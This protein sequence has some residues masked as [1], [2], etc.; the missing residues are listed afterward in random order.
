MI[1]KRPQ[2]A[3]KACDLA[4]LYNSECLWHEAHQ[5]HPERPE[6]LKAI[7]KSFT[8]NQSPD[9]YFPTTK[10]ASFKELTLVHDEDYLFSLESSCLAGKSTFQAQGNYLCEDSFY[11]IKAAAG[12]AIEAAKLALK[13]KNAF[14]LTRPPG[15]H[16]AR[17]TAEGFC[18][19]NHAALACETIKAEQPDAKVLILDIDVHHGNGTQKIYEYRPDVFFYSIHISPEVSYPFTGASEENGLEK[20]LDYTLNSPLPDKSTGAEWLDRINH[21]LPSVFTA[22]SPDFII[23]SLGFDAHK[24]DPT[25]L[26]QLEDQDFLAAAE[27]IASLAKKYQIPSTLLLEGGYDSATLERLTADFAQYFV[28]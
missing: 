4:V 13:G 19:I 17:R 3:T 1:S 21:K 14:A 7:V 20:G 5:I 9:F 8:N 12:L 11:S 18:F 2:T 24:D 6:R 26:M 16:A 22:F 25:E 15:H 28:Y 27:L 10:A 23:L